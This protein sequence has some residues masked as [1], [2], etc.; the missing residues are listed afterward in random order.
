[1]RDEDLRVLELIYYP[2][3]TKPEN[4]VKLY[5]LEFM[6][7]ADGAYTTLASFT[8]ITA[9]CNRNSFLENL[10]AILNM[11]WGQNR[12]N[13]AKAIQETEWVYE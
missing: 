7:I 13:I 2:D 6:N 3:F 12:R 4:F 10:I 9:P 5:E 8:N 11:C 1:M